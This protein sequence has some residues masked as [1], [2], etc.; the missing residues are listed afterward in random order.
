[1]GKITTSQHCL[2][3]LIPFS[4]KPPEVRLY[5][6]TE[7]LSCGRKPIDLW[8]KTVWRN[9]FGGKSAVF[10]QWDKDVDEQAPLFDQVYCK[11][12]LE[13][14]FLRTS[15]SLGCDAVGLDSAAFS[16]FP[17]TVFYSYSF[18]LLRLKCRIRLRVLHL[19]TPW[20]AS[21][22]L[23]QEWGLRYYVAEGVWW[24]LAN[25]IWFHE[26]CILLR[27]EGIRPVSMIE[28]CKHNKTALM[29][30]NRPWN[31]TRQKCWWGGGWATAI[32]C[33]TT[34]SLSPCFCL[35]LVTHKPWQIWGWGSGIW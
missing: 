32:W 10:C 4:A 19:S 11:P 23:Q 15:A 3:L 21:L 25:K 24:S 34:A 7:S 35:Q 29:N 31:N 17:C 9:S 5:T 16:G 2:F 30:I 18:L 14:F 27:Q 13:S 22:S 20:K 33:S 28:K 12:G 1:M 8:S 26:V 6:R